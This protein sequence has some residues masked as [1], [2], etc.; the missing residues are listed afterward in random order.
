M[1]RQSPARHKPRPAEDCFMTRRGRLRAKAEILAGFK[2]RSFRY[3]AGPR[4]I[5]VLTEAMGGEATELWT[6]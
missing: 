1:T 5:Q 2:A 3:G 6:V 4:L